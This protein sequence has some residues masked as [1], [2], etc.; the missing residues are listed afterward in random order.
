M[1]NMTNQKPCAHSKQ[2]EFKGLTDWFEVFRAGDNV[3][4]KGNPKTW[5]H[6]DLDSMVANHTAEEP[7][8]LVVGHPKTNDPAYG[9][10]AQLKRDGDLLLA[11]GANIVPEFESAVAAKMY[12]NRSI[13]VV[14]T[15]NGYKLKH[16]GFLG[17]AAPAVPGLKEI[18]HNEADNAEIYEFA[19][20][21]AIEGIGWRLGSVGRVFRNFKN[22]FIE[23]KGIEAAEQMFPEYVLDDLNESSAT[24]R[25]ELKTDSQFSAEDGNELNT[26]DTPKEELDMKTFNEQQLKE[27]V[28]AA[29]NAA[30][31]PIQAENAKLKTD[32]QQAAF[33]GR[34]ND[35]KTLVS[36]LVNEGKLLPASTAGV[37]EFM[38]NLAAEDTTFEFSAAEGEKAK[39]VTPYE[40][41]S[42]FL[43]G[44]GKQIEFNKKRVDSADDVGASS[45]NEHSFSAPSGMSVDQDRAE[46]DRKALNYSKAHNVDYT[47]ALLIVSQE[48]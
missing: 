43:K 39:E 38:A 11:K 8:P 26:P 46:L 29:V 28:D 9:W 20:E 40:F 13:S 24:I 34:L 44:L 30:L 32:A 14:P 3:D 1:H 19:A 36:G 7:A 21:T 23:E 25:S 18:L 5:T 10:T 42:T 35:A 48:D 41:M 45:S 16:I 37:A 22:W 27:A 17:A 12:R 47:E 33:N 15:D 2:Y 6:A 4:S 31:E